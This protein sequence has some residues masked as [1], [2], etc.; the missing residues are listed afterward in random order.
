LPA[1]QPRS[2]GA[3]D[4]PVCPSCGKPMHLIRRGPHPEHGTEYEVQVFSLL[5]V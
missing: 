5:Y 2:F 3:D 4:R 1:K